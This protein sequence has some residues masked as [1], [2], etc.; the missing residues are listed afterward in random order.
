MTDQRENCGIETHRMLHWIHR[1]G[2]AE[3]IGLAAALL[4]TFIARRATNSVIIVAYAGAWA[5]SLGYGGR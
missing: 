5:E 1:Y 3:I 2:A 4:A